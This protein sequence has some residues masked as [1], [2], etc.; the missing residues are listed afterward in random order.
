MRAFL[1][2]FV[3][4][5]CG[6]KEFEKTRLSKYRS[7]HADEALQGQ[8]GSPQLHDTCSADMVVRM[9]MVMATPPGWCYR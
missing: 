2:I 6:L 4:W 5:S 7:C 1:A 9:R 3:M 8:N